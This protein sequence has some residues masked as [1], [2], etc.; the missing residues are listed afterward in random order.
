M[1]DTLSNRLRQQAKAMEV[2][3]HLNAA[4]YM[5]YAG[6]ELDETER[7]LR[8]LAKHLE[9]NDMPGQ[10]GNCTIVADRISERLGKGV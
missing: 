7:F 10:A 8:Q 1:A 9:A 6:Q 3:G 5:I 4:R 2:E